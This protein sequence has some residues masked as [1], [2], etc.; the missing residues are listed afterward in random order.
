MKQHYIQCRGVYT[1][2]GTFD[3]LV[4]NPPY[5]KSGSGRVNPIDEKAVAR[6]EIKGTLDDSVK[7]ASYFLKNKGRA[8]FVY[9]ASRGAALLASLRNEGL[10]PKKMQVVYGYPGAQGKLILVE[11]V[12]NGGEELDILP[13]FYV[14]KE[15]GGEYSKEMQTYYK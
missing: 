11:S 6:H 5:R 9:P 13:P 2:V 10:E 1:N 3:W 15:L 14:F 4:C 12:K 7:A 8:A